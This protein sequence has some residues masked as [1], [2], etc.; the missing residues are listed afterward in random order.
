MICSFIFFVGFIGVGNE[1][2]G[3][4]IGAM[5][6]AE[7]YGNDLIELSGI[8]D[9]LYQGQAEP[10]PLLVAPGGFFDKDWF[11]KLLKIS[12]SKVIDVMTLHLYNLGPGSCYSV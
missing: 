11:A 12:G 5:V 1:L 6:H 10:K 9:N 2:S 4:G 7:Q 8:I 3:K